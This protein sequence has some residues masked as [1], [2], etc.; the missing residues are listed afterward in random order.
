MVDRVR[1]PNGS[2]STREL[3][4]HPGAA[5]ILPILPD[6]RIILVHQYR[7]PVGQSLWEIPAGK[8]ES[9][10]DPLTCAKRELLEET[11]YEAATWEEL[12]SFYTSPGFTD[13]QIT[14][15][16]AR[17]LTKVAEP[18]PGEI[19]SQDLFEQHRLEKMIASG[20]IRDGKTMLALLL[21][22]LRASGGNIH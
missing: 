19:T 22:E 4:L 17:D 15:F 5:A 3:V 8:L 21:T 12:L 9:G 7:H 10:E 2:E 14:L 6:G 1:L 16:F 11:G 18:R 13:E 20:E